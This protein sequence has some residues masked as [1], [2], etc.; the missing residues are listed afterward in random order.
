MEEKKLA[1]DIRA[2]IKKG[3]LSGVENL[4][5]ANRESL[6]MMTP[7]GTWLHVAATFGKLDIIKFLIDA[8]IDVNRYGGTFDGGAINHAAAEGHIYVVEFLLENGAVLDVSES[9]INPL[10]AAI[11]GGHLNIVKLL[12][13]KGIDFKIKYTSDTMENMD[14]LAFAKERGQTQIAEYLSTI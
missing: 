12:I 13:N 8:G 5:N 9:K 1:K 14:A 4:I 6:N 11:Y 7:F 2:A 10:F 3:D